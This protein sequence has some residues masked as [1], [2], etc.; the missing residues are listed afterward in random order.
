MLKVVTYPDPVLSKEAE[1]VDEVTDEIRDLMDRMLTVMYEAP[2][3]GLAAPQVDV[4]KRIIVVDINR[5]EKERNPIK[6]V[7]PE[8]VKREGEISSEEGCLSLPDFTGEIK[9]NKA[10]AVKGLDENGEEV[11]FEANGI[12]AVVFQ[13]EI[14]HLDGILLIDRVSRLKRDIYRR[15]RKK[16][17]KESRRESTEE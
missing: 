10:I 9:R 1:P 6:L 15:K 16:E 3:V 5:D 17:L 4:G 7:N 12:L 8:I 14:D 11:F 2:G 13:H